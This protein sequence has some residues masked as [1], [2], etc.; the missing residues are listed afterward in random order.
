MNKKILIASVIAAPL[1]VYFALANN[2]DDM[3]FVTEKARYK[4]IEKTVS[5]V[6]Q[7]S[8]IEM[9]NVGAQVSGQIETIHVKM[10]DRVKKGDLIVKI[11]ST[12]QQNEVKVIAA[13]LGS[14]NAQLR[15]SQAALKAAA[16]KYDRAKTLLKNA[17]VSKREYE[18]TENEYEAARSKVTESISLVKQSEISLENAKKNLGYA[19]ITAPIDGVIV[20]LPVKAGQTVNASFETPVIAQ[21][22]DLSA[23]EILIEISE[24]DILK[25]KEGQKTRFSILSEETAYETSIKSIDPALTLL[26]NDKY[27]GVSESN[28]AIY[29][30]ARV[31]YPNDEGKFRIG[32]T[33]QNAIEIES[34][35]N[36]LA[37]PVSAVNEKGGRK[38]VMTLADKSVL[39]KEI[40]T[41][42][43]NDAYIEVKSGLNEGDEVIISQMSIRQIEAKADE[44]PEGADAL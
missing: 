39:E 7:V 14:Y 35:K 1:I 13:Q 8:A 18:D 37:I 32:M 41:G 20:S 36:V 28:Q 38:F 40:T 9:I 25:I 5:A 19:T 23:V 24:G 4:D 10:G 42:L 3:R 16:S 21:I 11:D 6:G 26:T 34:V 27:T 2:G 12:A 44:V 17:A 31:E 15:S 29:Y 33:T 43:S 22:A 30:Y